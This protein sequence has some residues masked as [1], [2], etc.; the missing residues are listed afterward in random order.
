MG[1]EPREIQM[2]FAFK[3]RLRPLGPLGD[4]CHR[5]SSPWSISFRLYTAVAFMYPK[6]H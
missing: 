4:P 5:K 1:G 3:A 6:I 2:Q